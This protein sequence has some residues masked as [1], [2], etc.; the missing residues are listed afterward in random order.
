M[1]TQMIKL[2]AKEL[3]KSSRKRKRFD[4]ERPL[5]LKAISRRGA[6]HG[7]M[8]LDRMLSKS[9]KAREK[10]RSN[11]LVNINCYTRIELSEL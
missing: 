1:F 10:D 11:T 6:F 3:I 8:L 9:K 2:Y 4:F 5:L 7:E